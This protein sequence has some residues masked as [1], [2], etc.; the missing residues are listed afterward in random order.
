M[1]LDQNEPIEMIMKRI[2]N[3]DQENTKIEPTAASLKFQDYVKK[4][5]EN[6][7]VSKNKV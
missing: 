3:P 2:V 1:A 6:S 4:I 7:K 5:H